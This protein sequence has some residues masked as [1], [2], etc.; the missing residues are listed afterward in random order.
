M[1][2]GF[3]LTDRQTNTSKNILSWSAVSKAVQIQIQNLPFSFKHQLP[4]I[5]AT[6]CLNPL[7]LKDLRSAINLPQ[8]FSLFFMSLR[9][10][11]RHDEEKRSSSV[12]GVIRRTYTVL[13]YSQIP[14]TEQRKRFLC[15]RHRL[16]VYSHLLSLQIYHGNI[17]LTVFR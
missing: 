16:T 7:V 14:S 13:S 9:L 4:N 2:I 5:S 8:W 10:S 1:N 3:L 17:L 12:A 15:V 6:C 11:V